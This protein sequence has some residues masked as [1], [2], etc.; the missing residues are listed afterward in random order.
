MH[1]RSMRPNMNLTNLSL[2]HNSHEREA[3]NQLHLDNQSLRNRNLS[4][5]NSSAIVDNNQR[6]CPPTITIK[7]GGRLSPRTTISIY[8]LLLSYRPNMTIATMLGARLTQ[9][10]TRGTR[11]IL[12]R[13]TIDTN[14]RRQLRAFRPNKL[15]HRL[16]HTR[17]VNDKRY[18]VYQYKANNDRGQNY[19]RRRNNSSSQ[20][21]L[22]LR[23]IKH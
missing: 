13:H 20:S 21:R 16:H 15:A 23:I 4:Q 1:I 12:I 7:H 8:T 3:N 17:L 5:Q 14:P 9:H 11:S 2:N 22:A 10:P 19:D 6:T 18:L